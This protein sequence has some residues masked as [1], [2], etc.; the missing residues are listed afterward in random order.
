MR[1]IQTLRENR[2]DILRLYLFG[3]HVSGTAREDSDIDLAIFLDRDEIDGFDEEV[4]LL[5]FTR[6]IDLRIKPHAF[7]RKDI[8]NAD[9]FIRD[10]ITTGKRII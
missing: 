8:D 9:P 3:S 10:I 5:R 1:Y 4:Q 7:S 2:I 6:N